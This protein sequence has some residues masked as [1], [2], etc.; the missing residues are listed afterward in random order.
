M[1]KCEG[2]LS[3]QIQ[4]Y[5]HHSSTGGIHVDVCSKDHNDV[6]SVNCRRNIVDLINRPFV[7][8][9]VLEI[10]LHLPELS[11]RS[12]F[13]AGILILLCLKLFPL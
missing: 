5:N 10:K 1:S 13:L 6:P 7:L 12:Q 3:Y 4:Q 11:A 9:V 2:L 8:L